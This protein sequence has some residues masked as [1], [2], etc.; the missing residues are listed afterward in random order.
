MLG[1]PILSG[2]MDLGN[3]EEN[4]ID[5]RIAKVGV[6]VF[7]SLISFFFLRSIKHHDHNI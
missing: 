6:K 2:R 1:H 7:F 4:R 3:V 5:G